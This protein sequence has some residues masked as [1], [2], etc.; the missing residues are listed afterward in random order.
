MQRSTNRILT[1][2]PGRLPNPDDQDDVLRARNG[3]DTK[4]FDELISKDV[5]VMVRRQKELGIDIMSDG[6]FW[7]G[8]DL[9]F[10]TSRAE[11]II[12]RPLNP[13]EVTTTVGT[14][15]EREGEFADFWKVYDQMG[16]TPRPGAVNAPAWISGDRYV[17][18]GPVKS[19]GPGAINHEIE[20]VRAGITAAGANVEDFF[21]PVLGPGWL[22]HFVWDEY[23]NDEEKY[24]YALAEIVKA[25]FKAVVDAGFILQIDDPGLCDRWGMINPAVTVQEYRR[26]E[27]IRIDATNWALEGIPEDR[28][29]YH[30]CWG[31]WHT[32][33]TTDIPFEYTIDLMLKVNAGA[34]SVEAAD[35]RHE[36]D[37]KL[38]EKYKLP[39]GK[40]YIP[41]VVA[42]KTTTIE[43]PELVADRIVRYA[44]LMGRENIIAGVDCGVGNRSYPEVGWAKLRALVEGAALASRMLWPRE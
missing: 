13:G 40:I 44:N 16:N 38:W 23:Y 6:E 8:R 4:R 39:D 15:R 33:H 36:L 17:I 34:Y 1:T 19:R 3:D 26:H 21:F 11:G 25:D 28:V 43:P 30:T 22:D 12:G 32:P 37:W 27:A 2:H 24:C 7:K 42:H 10:Y 18:S 9:K 20:A 41:G 14:Q 35:V 31:S 5:A 29:R